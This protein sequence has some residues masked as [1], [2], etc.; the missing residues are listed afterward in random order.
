MVRYARP[1]L[2]RRLG[3]ADVHPAVEGAGIGVDDFDRKCPAR[4]SARAVF[5]DAVAPAITTSGGFACAPAPVEAAGCW[6]TVS[7]ATRMDSFV[8]RAAPIRI[9]TMQTVRHRRDIR[10][11]PHTRLSQEYMLLVRVLTQSLKIVSILALTVLVIAG[12]VA[13]FDYW[14]DRQQSD[15]I[16]RPVTITITEDDDGGSVADKLTDAEL[17]Q[18]GFYFETMFRFSGDDLRPGSYILRHGMSVSD[19]IDAISVPRE[20]EVEDATGR[21]SRATNL[22]DLHRGGADRAVCRDASSRPA[23]RVTR[24]SSST[25]RGTRW[26]TGNLG[27][28]LRPAGRRRL[29][30]FLFPETYD[31]PVRCRSPGCDRLHAEQLRRPIRRRH[32][33]E[34][35]NADGMSIYEVVTLASIVEREAAVPEER[36]VRSPACTSTA[37]MPGMGLQADPTVQYVVGNADEDWW[38]V[39]TRQLL[40]QAD[41]PP[42]DTYPPN[43]CPGFR[44]GRSRIRVCGRSRRS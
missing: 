24:R 40:E 28:A 41:G 39:L 26:A 44:L 35:A 25:S 27:L 33:E 8:M 5:P 1:L 14:T 21:R 32:A 36:P 10:T 3:G 30:G 22:G 4:R 17:V 12:A 37:S 16:G 34:Q 23:G 38:P 19:I 7:F 43:T 15:Q 6:L 11:L 2:D 13:F 9:E 20:E 29:E 42:Y 31:V 18:Y